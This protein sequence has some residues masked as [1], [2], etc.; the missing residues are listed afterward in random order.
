MADRTLI[1]GQY[2]ATVSNTSDIEF[3][4][5]M[6][7]IADIVKETGFTETHATKLLKASID[8]VAWC[9]L[10]FGFSDKDDKW[11]IRSYQKEQILLVLI[12]NVEILP[13]KK[14]F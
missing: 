4:K 9:E 1:E 14:I 3:A 7:R 2:R 6:I 12:E 11:F 5:G 8:P 10:M 13:L